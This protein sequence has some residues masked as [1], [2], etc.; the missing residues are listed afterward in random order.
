MVR[1]AHNGSAF[2]LSIHQTLVWFGLVWFG[3]V[4]FGL[5]WFGF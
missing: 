3:L 1:A 5:V 4:W 2:V